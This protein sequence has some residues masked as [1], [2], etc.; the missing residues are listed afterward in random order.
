[1]NSPTLAIPLQALPAVRTAGIFPHQDQHFTQTYGAPGWQ[2][3]SL[4]IYD[5]HAQIRLAGN[6]VNLSP[7]DLTL[8]PAGL[9]TS[10]HLPKPGHHHC[11][12]FESLPEAPSPQ[13]SIA[14]PL[15]MP[16]GPWREMAQQKLMWIARLHAMSPKEPIASHAASAAMQE[17]LLWLALLPKQTGSPSQARVELALD[18]AAQFIGQNLS[19]PITIDQIAK[20]SQLSQNYLARKFRQRFGLTIPRYILTRRIQLAR[21]LLINTHLPV[22]RIGADV[23]LPDAHH[24]NK[25]FRNIT[26]QSPTNFR[27]SHLPRLSTSPSDKTQDPR[28]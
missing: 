2:F 12:H 18:K 16:L 10:Y 21:D 1:M 9:I 6:L 17:M 4:H 23:G 7:G 28:P 11:I 13:Q 19:R 20:E 3:H 26:S 15:H 14:L 8:S 22:R 24:F 25:Q 27:N 5:Y